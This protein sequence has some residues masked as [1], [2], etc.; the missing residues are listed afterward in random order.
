MTNR[1]TGLT[2][3]LLMCLGLLL[4]FNIFRHYSLFFLAGWLLFFS[5]INKSYFNKTSVHSL[6]NGGFVSLLIIANLVFVLLLEVINAMISPAWSYS[7]DFFDLRFDFWVSIAVYLLFILATFET[8]IFLS[9]LL[10]IRVKKSSSGIHLLHSAPLP[11][12]LMTLPLF[13]LDSSYPGLPIC[14]FVVGFFLFTD[15]VHQRL[16]GKS[17]IMN[18]IMSPKYLLFLVLLSLLMSVPSEYS[19]LAQYV[20]IYSNLPFLDITL[21][22]V[23]LV[24]LL[25]WVPLVGIWINLFGI[26]GHFSDIHNKKRRQSHNSNRKEIAS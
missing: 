15:L 14:F 24:I 1:L 19:N 5:F 2:G 6:Q 26:A 21:F 20:W 4:S 16:S 9:R 8:Y 11:V 10:K 7:F 25:G 12:M 17:V 13:L 22:N 3:F 23:P 18:S